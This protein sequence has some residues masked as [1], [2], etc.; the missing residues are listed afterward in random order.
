[1]SKRCRK[2]DELFETLR[3]GAHKREVVVVED[4]DKEPLLPPPKRRRRKEASGAKKP[5]EASVIHIVECSDD[6]TRLPTRS[7]RMAKWMNSLTRPLNPE[8]DDAEL[9]VIK[10]LPLEKPEPKR[11]KPCTQQLGTNITCCEAPV[12]LA[13]SKFFATSDPKSEPRVALWDLA[14]DGIPCTQAATQASATVVTTSP[15]RPNAEVQIPATEEP[16]FIKEPT[17]TEAEHSVAQNT[18]QSTHAPAL[19]SAEAL[20]H[21]LRA[22]REDCDTVF[23]YQIEELQHAVDIAV[24]RFTLAVTELAELEQQGVAEAIS[25]LS[26]PEVPDYKFGFPTVAVDVRLVACKQKDEETVVPQTA[27]IAENY[28]EEKDLFLSDEENLAQPGGES[29]PNRPNFHEMGILELKE[30]GKSYGIKPKSK[31]F[32]ELKLSQVWDSLAH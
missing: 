28:E 32:L 8:S 21:R 22:L 2:G 14:A 19:D 5:R 11:Q 12:V 7:E 17:P 6:A 4:V 10:A 26:A 20:R 23:R 30:L 13:Q 27:E 15:I 18:G 25:A 3:F 24:H 9:S 31:A 16:V 1:M 29:P